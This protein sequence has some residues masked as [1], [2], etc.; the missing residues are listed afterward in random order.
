VGEV[1]SVPTTSE[2]HKA[3][4]VTLPSVQPLVNPMVVPALL[5]LIILFQLNNMMEMRRLSAT[6][7]SLQASMAEQCQPSDFLEDATVI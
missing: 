6:L 1:T 3:E 5:C 4:Q 7:Q 2:Q